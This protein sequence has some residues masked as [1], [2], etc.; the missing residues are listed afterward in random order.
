MPEKQY[1][2]AADSEARLKALERPDPAARNS[3]WRIPVMASQ[4]DVKDAIYPPAAK[5]RQTSAQS[6]PDATW[7]TITMDAKDFDSTSAV[8]LAT[9]SVTIRIAGIYEILGRVSWDDQA[10]PAGSLYAGIGV[11]AGAGA[12][13][14]SWG[15]WAPAAAAVVRIPAAVH[16]ALAIGDVIT[17]RGFQSTGGLLSTDVTADTRSFL[18]LVMVS[19]GTLL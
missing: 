19:P 5:M 4:F 14:E 3:D 18:S 10:V 17:L 7:T 1:E 12:V 9:D 13:T 8:D 15:G 11:N 16:L 2:A 6:V